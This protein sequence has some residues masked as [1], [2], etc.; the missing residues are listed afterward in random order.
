ML[1][2]ARDQIGTIGTQQALPELA[3]VCAGPEASARAYL[4]AIR[5]TCDGVGLPLRTLDLPPSVGAEQYQRAVRSLNDDVSVAGILALQPLPPQLPR[6][7]PAEVIDPEKDIDGITMVNAGR[8]L[9]GLPTLVPSTPAGG[10]AILR[11]Y[12]IPLAGAHAVVVGRSMVVGKPMAALLLAADATVTICHTGT[13]D[14]ARVAREADILVAAAGQPGLITGAMVKPGATVIDFGVNVIGGR[15][16]GDAAPEVAEV[17][18][19]LTPVPGGTGVVT[20]AV[21]VS[22]LLQAA[23]WRGRWQAGPEEQT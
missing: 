13:V 18:G 21:L 17:A 20:N 15:L 4:R 23:G 16:V 7:L 6:H 9:A 22:N 11:H 3:V 10:M 1:A 19:A 14:L 5:K 2:R 12:E 8:L